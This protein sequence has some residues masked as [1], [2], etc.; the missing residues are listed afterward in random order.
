MIRKL[1]LSIPMRAG[2]PRACP[3]DVMKSGIWKM[4]LV[5]VCGFA[6]VKDSERMVRRVVR[7][8]V[9]FWIW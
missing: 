2:L 8:I 6:V 4:K 7:S 9:E 3:S 5:G 1:K